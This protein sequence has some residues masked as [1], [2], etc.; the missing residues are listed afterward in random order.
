MITLKRQISLDVDNT[1]MGK[2]IFTK[3]DIERLEKKY[4]N[5]GL[6]ELETIRLFYIR[7]Y[8]IISLLDVSQNY[9]EAIF[10]FNEL[11]EFSSEEQIYENSIDTWE[12]L[13]TSN[14][15]EELEEAKSQS[16]YDSNKRWMR[17]DYGA[18]AISMNDEEV[19]Q[20]IKDYLARFEEN[21]LG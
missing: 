19:V 2:E 21:I 3:K 15:E 6:N 1:Y 12:F 18:Y 8:E 9:D 4:S 16:S 5:L 20:H 14:S 11:S 7:K 13:K 17:F 10:Q